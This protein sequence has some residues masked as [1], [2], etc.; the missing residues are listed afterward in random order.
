MRI[1]AHCES[2]LRRLF[3]NYNGTS[4]GASTLS[5]SSKGA[6]LTMETD[7]INIRLT[8]LITIQIAIIMIT[9]IIRDCKR[10][11]NHPDRENPNA[12]KTFPN[13]LMFNAAAIASESFATFLILSIWVRR[14]ADTFGIEMQQSSA[15]KF[16][17][18]HTPCSFSSIRSHSARCWAVILLVCCRCSF[19][20]AKLSEVELAKTDTCPVRS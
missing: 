18:P 10:L 14:G 17:I 12:L 3:Y 2:S 9:I 20:S 15:H 11:V 4:I 19:K 8:Q 16:S 7:R 6:Y 1:D 5:V 13:Q